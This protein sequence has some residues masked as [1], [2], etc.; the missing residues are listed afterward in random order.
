MQVFFILFSVHFAVYQYI[1]SKCLYRTHVN[2]LM[3]SVPF[4]HCYLDSSCFFPIAIGRVPHPFVSECFHFALYG[5][6]AYAQLFC[7]RNTDFRLHQYC[8]LLPFARLPLRFLGVHLSFLGVHFSECVLLHTH[9][10]W[11]FF[12]S[13]LP[14]AVFHPHIPPTHVHIFDIYYIFL[15]NNWL[16]CCIFYR[17][18][19]Q[20]Y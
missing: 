17:I 6:Y 7:H 8:Y 5:R 4:K 11:S 14:P 9:V 10:F 15:P 1:N 3:S 13:S 19:G 18:R 2:L 16:I 20:R 12:R